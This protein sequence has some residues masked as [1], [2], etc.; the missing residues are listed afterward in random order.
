MRLDVVR[1]ALDP[2]D[3]ADPFAEEFAL[4]ADAPAA[5]TPI[6]AAAPADS[7]EAEEPPPLPGDVDDA[8]P[9]PSI[10]VRAGLLG[11]V[12]ALVP[13]LGALARVRVPLALPGA[14]GQSAGLPGAGVRARYG[15]TART[16]GLVGALVVAV[17]VG[18][19]VW[20]PAAG[21]ASAD[22]TEV[23][24][25]TEEVATL[26]A[27]LDALTNQPNASAQ[28]ITP[29]A[30]PG[31][32]VY[33]FQ[34]PDLSGLGKSATDSPGTTASTGPWQK[35][36]LGTGSV[37][38]GATGGASATPTASAAKP[39]NRGTLP[40][41]RPLFTNGQNIYNCSDFKTWEDAQAVFEANQPGDP[42]I[43]DIGG[44]G[45]ACPSL[46]RK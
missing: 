36:D 10:V 21:G 27:R 7:I 40:D 35:F 43:L 20:M 24:R 2:M 23:L 6:D 31:S 46:K 3:E 26:T 11:R 29:I 34:P 16:A 9:A 42:N 13:A 38:A 14:R 4:P 8:A 15:S 33:S 19:R 28:P 12:L 30:T 22:H 41:G 17:L 5:V 39:T 44:S 18:G 37:R 45:M 32:T 1:D 25:L